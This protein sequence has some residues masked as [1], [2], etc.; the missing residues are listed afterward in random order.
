MRTKNWAHNLWREHE[1]QPLDPV[2]NLSQ[3]TP[4]CFTTQFAQRVVSHDLMQLEK[5]RP[6]NV[7][8]SSSLRLFYYS[9]QLS[10]TMK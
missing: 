3:N 9:M 1:N 8:L 4:L 10:F 5:G 2:M 7:D 6:A